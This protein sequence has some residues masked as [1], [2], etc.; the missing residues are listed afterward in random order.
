MPVNRYYFVLITE[1]EIRLRQVSYLPK[2]TQLL[3]GESW[4]LYRNPPDF[5]PSC[6]TLALTARTQSLLFTH[7][8]APRIC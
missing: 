3:E 1:E 8:Y 4:D 2:F 6:L 7:S 5:L